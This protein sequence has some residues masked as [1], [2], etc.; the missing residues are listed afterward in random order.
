M[1]KSS[2]A[3]GAGKTQ[4]TGN[5][6][7]RIQSSTAKANAGKVSSGTFAARAQTAAATNQKSSKK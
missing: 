1:A 6:A 5:A 7:A 2:S 3:K 4:M